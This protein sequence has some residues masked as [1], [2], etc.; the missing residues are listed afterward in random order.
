MRC[1]ALL[2]A[3]GALG[4]APEDEVV[5]FAGARRRPDRVPEEF[6]DERDDDANQRL[7]FVYRHDPKVRDDDGDAA[8]EIFDGALGAEDDVDVAGYAPRGEPVADAS[9]QCELLAVDALRARALPRCRLEQDVGL[10]V[11]DDIE[12]GL[13]SSYVYAACGGGSS[14]PGM[15]T[16]RGGKSIGACTVAKSSMRGGRR[17]GTSTSSVGV[18]DSSSVG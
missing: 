7:R 6:V 17:E 9:R 15:R 14:S 8:E 18:S 5:H 3:V 2:D 11:G 13:L 1:D 10:D 4:A 12:R 16:T